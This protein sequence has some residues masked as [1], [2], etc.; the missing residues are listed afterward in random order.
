VEFRV[1]GNLVGSA[2]AAPYAAP[3]DSKSAANGQ[4]TLSAVARDAAGNTATSA[5]TVSV[6]NLVADTGAPV[7]VLTSPV[8]GTT[9]SGGLML[10]A[11]AT[12]S[13][14]IA[15]VEFL[16]NGAVVRTELY[17]PY[18]IG[19]TMPSYGTWTI[20]ARAFDTAGNQATSAPVTVTYSA[21][22]APVVAPVANLLLNP[23]FEQGTTAWAFF[24]QG[25]RA[26][27]TSP[28]H[29]GSRA[30]SVGIASNFYSTI[31]QIV[32][33]QAGRTYKASTWLK[34]SQIGGRGSGIMLFWLDASGRQLREDSVTLVG[35]RDWTLMDRNFV[36]PAAAVK[37]KFE[38]WS[39]TDP[40]NS[41]TTWFDDAS[42]SMVQ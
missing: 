27:V 4:Y 3:W 2:T 12:D 31:E 7:V 20:V 24:D 6:N 38:L 32:T 29:G 19:W 34:Q 17:T 23:G 33:V 37:V 13:N 26:V 10:R 30:A 25:R 8:A 40:D 39:F 36:A 5:I 16:A 18:E 11:N 41:G 14:G 9:S 22:V 1:N 28:V 42:F 21:P 15:R 35:T